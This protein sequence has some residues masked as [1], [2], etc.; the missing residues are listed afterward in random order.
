MSAEEGVDSTRGHPGRGVLAGPLVPEMQRGILRCKEVWK[1]GGAE[2]K[3]LSLTLGI[4]I[5]DP[6][7]SWRSLFKPHHFHP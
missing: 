7:L 6:I 3:V 2:D 4:Q 1:T 5:Q